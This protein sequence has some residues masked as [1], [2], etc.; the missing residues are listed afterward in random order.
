MLSG[1]IRI[2]SCTS[3]IIAIVIRI[4]DNYITHQHRVAFGRS[5]M[6]IA[7]IVITRFRNQLQIDQKNEIRSM[8]WREKRLK[9]AVRING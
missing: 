7:N 5:A 8:E 4:I 1:K 6:N 9:I 3:R 2:K